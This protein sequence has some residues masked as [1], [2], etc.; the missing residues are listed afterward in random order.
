VTARIY[1]VPNRLADTVDVRFGLRLDTALA[2]AHDSVREAQD[3]MLVSLRAWVDEIEMLC[4]EPEPNL[5]RLAW[6]SN[7]VLGV[8]GI[9]GLTTLSRCGGL[10]GRA[11]ELMSAGWRTDMALIYVTAMGRMLEGADRAAEEA[12]VLVSLETMNKRLAEA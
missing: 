4:R 2:R 9:C 7:G 11:I 8:G 10:F 6:L 5:A 3:E 1:K 12:A